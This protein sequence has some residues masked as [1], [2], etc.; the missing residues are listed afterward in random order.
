[1]GFLSTLGIKDLKHLLLH[2][3]KSAA[4]IRRCLM[5][6]LWSSVIIWCWVDY[7]RRSLA[8]NT[9]MSWFGRCSALECRG[10]NIHSGERQTVRHSRGKDRERHGLDTIQPVWLKHILGLCLCVSMMYIL[11]VRLNVWKVYKERQTGG[12]KMRYGKWNRQKETLWRTNRWSRGGLRYLS[13]W[14]LNEAAGE[15]VYFSLAINWASC[16]ISLIHDPHMTSTLLYSQTNTPW[17]SQSHTL[18]SAFHPSHWAHSHKFTTPL[19]MP[20]ANRSLWR[21]QVYIIFSNHPL[22]T[23]MFNSYMHNVFTRRHSFIAVDV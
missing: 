16:N 20:S 22:N 4:D 5:R 3:L 23:K 17:Q 11:N 1:M 10:H 21:P 13:G 19:F 8:R 2:L 15:W 12:E 7:G 14:Q 18:T 9:R 6:L